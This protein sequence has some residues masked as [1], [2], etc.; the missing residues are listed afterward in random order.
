MTIASQQNGLAVDVTVEA[1][2]RIQTLPFTILTK[3]VFDGKSLFRQAC[4]MRFSEH[5]GEDARE[6]RD[7]LN[8]KNSDLIEYFVRLWQC[9]GARFVLSEPN[10]LKP[11]SVRLDKKRKPP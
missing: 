7:L 6:V 9:R 2:G 1:G 10:H 4:S 11:K 8:S 3:S 5:Q